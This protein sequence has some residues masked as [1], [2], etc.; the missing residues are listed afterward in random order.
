MAEDIFFDSDLT[1]AEKY[2]MVFNQSK[3]LVSDETNEI[4]NLANIS[5]LLKQAFNFYWV[6]FYRVLENQLI[7]GPFQ[8]TL[9]CTRIAFDKG[10]CGA[11]YSQ[12]ETIIVPDVEKFPGHI[13]CSAFSKSEIVV[14]VLKNEEVHLV[15]DVDS[16]VL[17]DFDETDKV[18]LEK[19]CRL[20]ES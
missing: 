17:N 9:A 12:K 20:L 18:W 5:S 2:E 19:I 3:A 1:K 13:A 4:A 15:L 11:C 10:V 8:G 14:P 16:D 6:G 7:L